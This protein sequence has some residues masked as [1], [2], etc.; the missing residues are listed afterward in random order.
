ML[1]AGA[2][3]VDV[4]PATDFEHG[5]IP[6]TVS[7]SLAAALSS[8]SLGEVAGPDDPVIFSCHGKYCPYSAYAAAKAVLW[9]RTRVYRFAG[10]FP[11]W[12]AAGRPVA[13]GPSSQTADTE[14]ASR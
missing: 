12:Q 13:T 4:R 8:D 11:T 9:G 6:G 5:H 3:L 1:E 10:G 2:I 7:L 14:V